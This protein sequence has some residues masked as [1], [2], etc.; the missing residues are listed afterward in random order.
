MRDALWVRMHC[1]CMVGYRM[2]DALWEFHAA[3]LVL[4]GENLQ[5]L[6][7]AVSTKISRKQAL[8]CG[9]FICNPKT[10]KLPLSENL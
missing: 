1:G 5:Y 3:T 9:K 2:R 10:Y 7:C 8:N 4:V 6:Y